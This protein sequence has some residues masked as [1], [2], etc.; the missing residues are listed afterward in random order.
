MIVDSSPLSYA[1]FL[2][3]FQRKKS[4]ASFM[5]CII[6]SHT[7]N[8]HS[9]LSSLVV[10][11]DRLIARG[12]KS[13]PQIDAFIESWVSTLRS[14]PYQTHHQK[15]SPTSHGPEEAAD[16]WRRAHLLRP[17]HCHCW[18]IIPPRAALTWAPSRKRLSLNLHRGQPETSTRH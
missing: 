18:G 7:L 16:H 9:T 2:I 8:P 1:F 17:I 6:F 5:L 3:G 13:L 11:I 15:A 4:C 14:L 12:E 10:R